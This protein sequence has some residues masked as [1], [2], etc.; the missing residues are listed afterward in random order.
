M[1][2]QTLWKIHHW[3][4]LYTGIVLI[5]LST[6]GALAVF[7]QEIDEALNPQFYHVDKTENTKW[8]TLQEVYTH[9]K[10]IQD[11]L[12][13]MKHRVI[14]IKVPEDKESPYIFNFYYKAGGIK[15]VL[16]NEQREYFINPYTLK[17]N[18]R[19][20]Q[21]TFTH[22]IRTLHVH[23]FEFYLGRYITGFFGVGLFI[24]IITGFL[25]YGNFMK[26]RA[27]GNI[28]KEKPRQKWADIH[29]FVGVLA[30]FFNLIISI[31]GAWLGLENLTKI[32]FKKAKPPQEKVVK[33]TQPKV[34]E[35][36][37]EKK[38]DEPD[39]DK[40]MFLTAKH[41]KELMPN[42]IVNRGKKITVYGNVPGQIY[43]REGGNSIVISKEN[44]EVI[45]K[46]NISDLK[47]V[48][49]L[50]YMQEGLHY[51]SYGGVWIKTLYCIMGIATGI[52]SITGYFLYFRRNKKMSPEK[53]KRKMIKY[54]IIISGT[55]LLLY[56]LTAVFNGGFT[57]TIVTLS[58]YAV[59]IFILLRILILVT[60]RGLKKIIL[61]FKKA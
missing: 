17:T 14:D 52:L 34:V 8:H 12:L 22:Y 47:A 50:Y 16:E 54:T 32:S 27:F 38:I 59:L 29:K 44:Y 28:R 40:V 2:K 23:L 37:N 25:I 5:I 49:K 3:I 43:R 11:S 9:F 1:S 24:S 18:Y 31:T 46:R 4:G 7:K 26:K 48:D 57:Y 42:Q 55:M 58:F 39:Y 60:Y 15:K 19:D 36:T 10:P 6:S 45:K 61:K 35:P 33:V 13:K 20:R 51:G 56:I 30:L 21:K 53:V 41:F